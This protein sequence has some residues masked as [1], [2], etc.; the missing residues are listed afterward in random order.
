MPNGRADPDRFASASLR[1]MAANLTGPLSAGA[2]DLALAIDADA[3]TVLPAGVRE[4]MVIVAPATHLGGETLVVR[5]TATPAGGV[6][7]GLPPLTFASYTESGAFLP[8]WIPDVAPSSR[9]TV[10]DATL[11]FAVSRIG[12]DGVEAE[13]PAANVAQMLQ[14]RVVGGVLG[15]VL[16]IVSAEKARVRRVARYC[17][18][19]RSVAF[20]YRDALDRTGADLAVPRL[21]DRIEFDAATRSVIT[22]S[23]READEDYRRRLTLSRPFIM[24]NAR[25]I[26]RLLNGPGADGEPNQGAIAGLGFASRFKVQEETNGFAVAIR[27]VS[28]DAARRTTFLQYL[29]DTSLILPGA[30]P[31]DDAV[32][33]A[34]FLP[35]AL[36]SAQAALRAD[37][38]AA[39]DWPANSAVA[40]LLARALARLGAARQALGAAGPW[41]VLRAQDDNGGSR[42]ELGLGVDLS[43]PEPAELDAM[44]AARPGALADLETRSAAA[45]STS[46]R[47]SL[48]SLHALLAMMEPRPSADDPDGQWLLGPCGLRTAH[49]LDAS[50]LY[51]SHLSA[52]GLAVTGPDTVQPAVPVEFSA[53]ME[54]PGQ[55]SS[56]VVLV[57]GLTSAAAAYEA[58]PDSGGAAPWETLTEADA[59]AAWAAVPPSGDT[60]QAS[61]VFKA[62]GIEPID[63]PSRSVEQLAGVSPELRATLRLDPALSADVLAGNLEAAA[64]LRRVT[65]ALRASHLVSVLPLVFNAGGARRVMLVV[66]VIGLPG[67]GVNLAERRA[68]AFRWYAVPLH[69]ARPTLGSVGSRAKFTAPGTGLWA[70]VVLGYARRGRNDPYEFRVTLPE[71]VNLDLRQYEFM[72]NVLE[73][74]FPIGVEINTFDIRQRHV[75]L[76]GDGQPDTL[77]P[78]VARTYR[79]FRRTS[80]RGQP[81]AGLFQAE[82]GD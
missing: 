26:R 61:L 52:F 22:L 63:K 66:G 14:A 62:A 47:R 18:A 1:N 3:S 7:V 6:P 65:S 69:G 35:G 55:A 50:R 40:P 51:V 64:T 71:G 33:A 38:R 39:F 5:A 56:N 28:T 73:R 58:D 70:V 27:V 67:A 15:Q 8:L 11:S 21:A 24:P 19:M 76:D 77:T 20:A 54:A 79:P 17:A 4:P 42:Y 2:R 32:H 30:S 49:R 16:V 48:N 25:S 59:L 41:Q 81:A 72:M 60:G 34:R 45:S 80:Y 23:A 12:A 74:S 10:V 37:L 78:S 13:I 53:M 36:A 29:R 9:I 43:G 68:T 46:E 44:A 82:S 57:N 75:D 31:S